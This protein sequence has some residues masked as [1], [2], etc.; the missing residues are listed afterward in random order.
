MD[1]LFTII[2]KLY[3]DLY[4]SQDVIDDLKKQ[5]VSI[6]NVETYSNTQQQEPK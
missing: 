4:R 1:E 5:L 6:K 2:G 3:F